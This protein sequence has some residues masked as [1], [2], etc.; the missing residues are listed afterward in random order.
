MAE[1]PFAGTKP[2]Y[3]GDDQTDED[4]FAAAQALGGF[5]VLVGAAR[6]TA[7]TR[8]LVDVDAVM[9]WLAAI[10]GKVAI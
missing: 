2:I 5:G 6:A 7:A 1:A 9:T 3:I 4:G 10:S 8:G